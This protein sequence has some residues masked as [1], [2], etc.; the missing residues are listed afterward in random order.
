MAKST[1]DRPL[2]RQKINV[3]PVLIKKW[4]DNY[5][6]DIRQMINGSLLKPEDIGTIFEH[7]GR[8]FEIVG[9]GEGR[10]LMLRETRSE[11][12]FYWECTRQFV[13]MK[14]GRF[15]R[16]F[17][18]TQ[19]GKTILV[20]MPYENAQ[21]HLAPKNTKRKK[22]VVETVEEEEEYVEN[23]I[24]IDNFDEDIADETQNEEFDI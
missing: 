5:L 1:I 18:K 4:E 13:Q 6:F 10:A 2:M 24:L 16:A 23:E 3:T 14:L 19:F 8:Y 20:D 9:M 21:L 12:V 11:G 17:Q 15:N 22:A 7:Q